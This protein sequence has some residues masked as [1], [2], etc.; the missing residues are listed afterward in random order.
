MANTAC[1]R[2]KISAIGNSKKF[3]KGLKKTAVSLGWIN[4]RLGKVAPKVEEA[5]DR[6]KG[7]KTKEIL[8]EERKRLRLAAR[9]IRH[10][11]HMKKT[12]VSY[13]WVK[14]MIRKGEGKV[15]SQAYHEQKKKNPFHVK[16]SGPPTISIHSGAL[17][18]FSDARAQLLRTREALPANVKQQLLHAKNTDQIKSLPKPARQVLKSYV[19]SLKAIRKK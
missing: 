19:S 15:V 9:N 10:K 13:G 1:D 11:E 7:I 18:P 2:A 17:K 6:F 14:N 16:P 8:P 5:V 12:A 3:T 4:K